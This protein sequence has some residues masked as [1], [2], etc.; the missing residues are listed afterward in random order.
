LRYEGAN[1]ATAVA[2]TAVARGWGLEELIP[3]RRTL[4]QIFVELTMQDHV[5]PASSNGEAA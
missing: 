2:E 4:E 3:E 5:H 1:P